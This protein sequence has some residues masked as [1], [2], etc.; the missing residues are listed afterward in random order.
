[1]DGSF[2]A[3]SLSLFEPYFRHFITES[4]L[5]FPRRSLTISNFEKKCHVR[6]NIQNGWHLVSGRGSCCLQLKPLEHNKN[7]L[8]TLLRPAAKFNSIL[9]TSSHF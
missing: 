4:V 7:N 6:A 2:L 5:I 1:M 8:A 3:M 9:S